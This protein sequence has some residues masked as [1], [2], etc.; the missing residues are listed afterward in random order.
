VKPIVLQCKVQSYDWGSQTFIPELLGVEPTGAPQAELWMGAHPAAPSMVDGVPLGDLLRADPEAMLGR[1]V[2]DRFGPQL[3]FLMKVLAA[4]HPLSL[5]A[6]PSRLRAIQRFA[7]EDADGIDR[8]SPFRS[9]RDANHKPELIC[10]LTEFEGLCG[11]R[12][13]DQTLMLLRSLEDDAA[14]EVVELLGGADPETA[15]RNSV[16]DLIRGRQ[17]IDGIIAACRRAAEYPSPD[18]IRFVESFRWCV[19]LSDEYPDDPGAVISLLMNYVA[20]RPGEAL[21]LPSGN[22]HAYLRGAGIE[23]MANSDNVLRGGLTH[24]HIDVDELLSV[25]DWNPLGDPVIRPVESHGVSTY[26]SP[27]DEFILHRIEV[28][29]NDVVVNVE[30][31]E[32][33]ICI[34]GKAKLC[35]MEVGQGSVLFIPAAMGEYTVSGEAKLFRATIN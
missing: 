6:H 29:T 13:V 21:C 22:L 14:Q 34:R 17:P 9:Y 18:A 28:T 33:L 27:S 7:E 24:K 5:Q 4:E 15:L 20:L 3:P 2:I 11:F 8:A 32:I 1:A 12:P 23:L 19:A 25:V 10:A 31:P 16:E 35:G 26:P 30:G